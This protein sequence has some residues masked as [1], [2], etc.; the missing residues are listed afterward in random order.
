[1]G[2]LLAGVPRQ[3]TD[4]PQLI[5]ARW[6]RAGASRKTIG[7]QNIRQNIGNLLPAQTPRPIRRHRELNLLKQIRDI[8]A[9]PI[10]G[11]VATPERWALFGSLKRGSMAGGATRVVERL[12][13]RRL[14]IRVDARPSRFIDLRPQGLKGSRLA[15]HSKQGEQCTTKKANKS[16]APAHILALYHIKKLC[17]F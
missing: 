17:H 5:G 2:S 12:P 7:P 15:R 8:G 6:K 3:K 10:I 9:V 11:E 1:M 4:A 13:T 16:Q 14:V